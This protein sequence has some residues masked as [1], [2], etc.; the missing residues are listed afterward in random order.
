[1]K[2]HGVIMKIKDIK[3]VCVIGAGSSGL[4]AIKELIDEGHQ[5]TCFEKYDQVGGAFY[6]NS[7]LE[8]PSSYDSTKLTISNY[9]M[10]YSSYPP[11]HSEERKF[12]SAH[13]Y[14][15]YLINFA[16]YFDLE[17]T[18]QYES[19]VIKVNKKTNGQYNVKVRSVRTKEETIYSYD[20]IAVCTGSNR[21]PKY[22]DINNKDNFRGVIHHSAYYKNAVR[23]EGKRVLCI[24]MGETGVDV[25]NEIAKVAKTCILS[26]RHRQPVIARYPRKRK[27]TSDSYTSN[28]LYHI[29]VNAGNARMNIEHKLMKKF[30]KDEFD[31]AFAEWN[32]KAGNYYNHFNIK[33][34]AFIDRILDKT[35]SINYSGIDHLEEDCVVFKD[36]EKEPID[37]IVLNTGYTDQF[38]FLENV[39]TSDMRQLY[40]HMI[41]PELGH[42]IVFIGWARP[43]VGGI[44][45]C[46]E[47]QSRYFALLCSGKKI[48]PEKKKL[49]R[50]SKRQANYEDKIYC[51]NPGVRS[52]VNYTKYMN[53]FAKLIGCSPWRLSTF[54]KPKLFYRLW[55]GSQMP[56]MYRLHGPHSNF[57]VAYK[58]IFNVPVAFKVTD[59]MILLIYTVVTNTLASIRIITPDPKY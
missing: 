1:M 32:L 33:S 3:K 15:K 41:H 19:E 52:L 12:W 59:I 13:E 44:P 38:S 7:N 58:T 22:I 2:K 20:A 45:A 43:A 16:K 27:Y 53:D 39:D 30:S 25:V 57:K 31:I 9:M 23:Y 35:L 37:F 11:D 40:K 5:V 55:V 42:E 26:L 17:K 54:I 24:G 56:Y 50:L 29:P 4:V 10:A 36:G 18:I 47:M 51:G 8:K 34:E 6:S 21:V 28:L 46:S 49:K 48:L 14:E